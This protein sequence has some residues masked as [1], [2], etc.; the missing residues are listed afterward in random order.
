[1]RNRYIVGML[2]VIMLIGFTAVDAAP[3][4]VTFQHT[5]RFIS[6]MNFNACLQ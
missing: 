6:N 2:G 3:T 1:M 4:T 5:I